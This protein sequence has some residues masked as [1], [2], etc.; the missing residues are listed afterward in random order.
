NNLYVAPDDPDDIRWV[1]AFNKSELPNPGNM[2][3]ET[4]ARNFPRGS[5]FRMELVN[6]NLL[7]SVGGYDLNLRIYEDY[8][9]RI[10]L[11]E[12]ARINFS[13]EPT[14]KIRISKQ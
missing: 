4:L 6:V 1:W 12:R 2:Y 8:D 3:V 5:L 9:F 10:R 7:K 13:L 11:S 14:T